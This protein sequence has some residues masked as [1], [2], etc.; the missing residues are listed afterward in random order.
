MIYDPEVIPRPKPLYWLHDMVR[1]ERHKEPGFELMHEREIGF[2]ALALR[3]S[4]YRGDLCIPCEREQ[5]NR[6]Q[7]VSGQA[8]QISRGAV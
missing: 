4:G 1:C 8:I 2:L 5:R 6:N 3:K 7:E